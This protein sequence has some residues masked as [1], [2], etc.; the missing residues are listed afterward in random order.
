[1]DVLLFLGGWFWHFLCK[2]TIGDISLIFWWH[3]KK[4]ISS[5]FASF[6][7]ED[8]PWRPTDISILSICVNQVL[9]PELQFVIHDEQA[10]MIGRKLTEELSKTMPVQDFP[11]NVTA[12][13]TKN[14]N[15]YK[16]DFGKSF[17]SRKTNYHRNDFTLAL[18][19]FISTLFAPP[20]VNHMEI[21][22]LNHTRGNTTHSKASK[23]VDPF[24]RGKLITREKKRIAKLRSIGNVKMP[25]STIID[26]FKHMWQKFMK[27]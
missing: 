5:G 15:F 1:M 12:H 10:D 21:L 9:V 25:Q 27:S 18:Q 23:T 24:R 3:L 2:T 17:G 19:V 26:L 14:P 7:I 6:E 4:K 8:G 16:N 20:G 13:L 11:V 22:V